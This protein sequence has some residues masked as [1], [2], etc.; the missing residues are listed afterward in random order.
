MFVLI[1]RVCPAL[2]CD[3]SNYLSEEHPGSIAVISG[4]VLSQHI[5][6]IQCRLSVTFRAQTR[7]DTDGWVLWTA[8]AEKSPPAPSL[9]IA[10]APCERAV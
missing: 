9:A 6:R 8:A 1:L 2:M 5:V 4:P 10:G 3:Y 7:Q